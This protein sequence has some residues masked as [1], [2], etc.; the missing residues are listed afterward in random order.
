M[1]LETLYTF[2]KFHETFGLSGKFWLGPR[3]FIATMD[4]KHC[5]LIL[6]NSNSMDKGDSYEFIAEI[7]GYGLITCKGANA[8][9]KSEIRF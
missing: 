1:C 4:P 8:P 6:N 2:E 7:V 9:P 5:E 3:L